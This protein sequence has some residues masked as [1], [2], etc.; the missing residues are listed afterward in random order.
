MPPSTCREGKREASV[1]DIEHALAEVA[2]VHLDLDRR[3]LLEA[4]KCE[5]RSAVADAWNAIELL[6]QETLIACGAFYGHLHQIVVFTRREIG[7]DHLGQI[8]EQ[9]PKALQDL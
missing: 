9:L 2:S 5:R 1:T 7:F 8:C 4:S 6:T 3:Q